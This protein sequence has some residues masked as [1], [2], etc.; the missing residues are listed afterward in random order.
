[1]K[2]IKTVRGIYL[3]IKE[4][5]YSYNFKGLTFYFSSKKYLE[6][7]KKTVKTYLENE[8]YKIKIKY[9]IN[10]SIDLFIIISYYKKIEKRG[11]R[12]YDNLNEKEITENVCFTTNI[13][14][15]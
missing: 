11:F 1:M 14:K 6:K 12:I 2:K 13:I 3:N 15:Y 8:I 9:N 7:F 10:I 4:S 5:D